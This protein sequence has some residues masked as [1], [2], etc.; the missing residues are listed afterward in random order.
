MKFAVFIAIT[1][2]LPAQSSADETCKQTKYGACFKVHGRYETYA[3]SETI[4]IIGTHKKLMVED[5]WESVREAYGDDPEGF[6]HYVLG[7]FTVCPLDKAVEGE[8]RRV[9]VQKAGNL[10]RVARSK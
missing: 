2:L 8:M 5:G 1:L 6:T 4:W 3:D 10:K 9:C 7:D